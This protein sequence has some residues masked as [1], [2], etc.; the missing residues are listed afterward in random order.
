MKTILTENWILDEAKYSFSTG[1]FHFV[2][3][4]E[5]FQFLLEG[6][7]SALTLVHPLCWIKG[8]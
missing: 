6:Q 3:K 7:T 5:L 8:R 1:K 4:P 2:E